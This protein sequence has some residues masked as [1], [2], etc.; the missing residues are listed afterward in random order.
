MIKNRMT[1]PNSLF[2]SDCLTKGFAVI[3]RST[4]HHRFL[5][6]GSVCK[7]HV[8]YSMCEHAVT[9]GPESY[10]RPH[11]LDS[12]I[13]THCTIGT[14][15]LQSVHTQFTVA[16]INHSTETIHQPHCA[17]RSKL[18]NRTAANIL[19]AFDKADGFSVFSEPDTCAIPV[20]LTE[21]FKL[22]TMH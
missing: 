6:S 21:P 10:G 11:F 2:P 22:H 18:S 1:T 9:R 4:H 15:A 20:G 14:H 16:D 13:H 3:T 19:R 8:M 7:G 5:M 17:G 12:A